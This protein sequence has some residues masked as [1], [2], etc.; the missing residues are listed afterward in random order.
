MKK[1]FC[2]L[3]LGVVI[4]LGSALGADVTGKWIGKTGDATITLNLKMDGARLAGTIN[5]SLSPGETP[6]D[7]GKIAGDEVSFYVVR[8]VN[9]TTVKVLWKGKVAGDDIKFTRGIEGQANSGTDVV[10]K[11]AN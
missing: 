5:N 4:T 11:K 7:T 6:I 3:L 2:V 10:V 8:N 9:E 1:I